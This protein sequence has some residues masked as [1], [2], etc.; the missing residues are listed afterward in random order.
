MRRAAQMLRQTLF[1]A[2]LLL[3]LP[4]ARADSEITLATDRPAV[5]DSSVVVPVGG[6]Q[7]ETGAQVTN[8]PGSS[9]VDLPQALLRYGLLP[10]TELRLSLPDYYHDASA[11]SGLGDTAI[12]VKQQLGPAGGFDVSLVGMLSLPSGA[13]GITSH[14]YDPAVQLP[15]SHSLPAR[16]TVAGQFA[17]YWPTVNG[18][19]NLTREATVLF[20]R[21]LTDPWDAFLE[22]AVDAPERGGTRSILHA[23]TAYKLS[24]RQQLDLHAAVGLSNAAARSYFGVGYSCLLLIH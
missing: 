21:Q 24:P 5:T 19:R 13:R 2:A 8:T 9:T 6:L 1:A 18:E 17:L 20:D 23:G 14:G 11:L 12:G 16:W 22:Y 15:W 4:E 3:A 10:D 7:L